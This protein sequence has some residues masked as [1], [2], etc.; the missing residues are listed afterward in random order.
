MENFLKLYGKCNKDCKVYNTIVEQDAISQIIKILDDKCF[1]NV[2]VRIMPDVHAGNGIVIGFTAPLTNMVNPS[3]VGVDIGCS[4]T[5]CITNRAISQSDIPLIEHRIKKEIPMGMDVNKSK[6][7]EMK[8]FIRFINSEYDKALSSWPEMINNVNISEDYISKMLKRIHMDEGLF[9][10]SLGTL[11]GGN[12]FIEI[13]NLYGN[14]TFAIHCGSRNFGLKVCKFWENIANQPSFDKKL[15]KEK[16]NE[17]KNNI[18]DKTLLP[19]KIEEIRNVMLSESATNGY[20]T[21]VDMSDY[22]SDM[23]IAQAYAKYNHLLISRK[24]EDIINKINGAKIID[25]IRTVHNYI[26]MNDHII[27]KG[28]IR[29]YENERM[30]VPFNM[31]DG[32]AICIGKS[33]NDWNNSCSHGSGRKMSRSEAKRVLSLEDFKQTMKDIYSTSVNFSTIDESPMAY[34]NTEDIINLLRDT[35]DIIEFVKPII[36]IKASSGV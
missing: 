2:P 14:Y 1:E 33:N 32:I 25:S 20:L 35:C 27:R 4:V 16:V 15:F 30:L 18:E 5:L 31:R 23:V 9:Y 13:G 21:G 26:D 19:S 29:S 12:H 28:A 24:I 10:K 3:H 8:E 11:G 7:F 6:V 22:I 34:K 17:L 36:S